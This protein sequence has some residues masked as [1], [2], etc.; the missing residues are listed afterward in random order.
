MGAVD[1][2]LEFDDGLF[3]DDVDS[4]M[5]IV[6]YGYS[7]VDCCT[8]DEFVELVGHPVPVGCCTIDEFTNLV[9]HTVPHDNVSLSPVVVSG[10]TADGEVK[11]CQDGSGIVDSAFSSLLDDLILHCELPD[12]LDDI[13]LSDFTVDIFDLAALSMDDLDFSALDGLMGCGECNIKSTVK[14]DKLY[15]F[16]EDLHVSAVFVFNVT[17]LVIMNLTT[18]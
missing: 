18:V 5:G 16:A 10:V 8:I 3:L 9:G 11:P 12:L 13:D 2:R 14:I 1:F 4:L 15:N 17:N 6:A 7:S